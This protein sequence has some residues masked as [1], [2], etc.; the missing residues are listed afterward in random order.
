MEVLKKN[1]KIKKYLNS[2]TIEN[3]C[4]PKNYIGLSVSFAKYQGKHAKKLSNKLKIKFH[5]NY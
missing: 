2:S 5:E 1:K 3:L 4:N